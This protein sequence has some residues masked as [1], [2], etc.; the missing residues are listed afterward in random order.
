MYD[1]IYPRT[2]DKGAYILITKDTVYNVIIGGK[3]GEVVA[4]C[5]NERMARRIMKL[6]NG[7]N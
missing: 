2:K 1:S 3:I 5:S 6:L 7:R 4:K